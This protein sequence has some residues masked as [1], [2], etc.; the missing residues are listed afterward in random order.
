[1]NNSKRKNNLKY[2]VYNKKSK[3]YNSSLNINE[4]ENSNL[5]ENKYNNYNDNITSN[6]SHYNYTSNSSTKRW[7][8]IKQNALSYSSERKKR[9]IGK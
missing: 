2:N 6:C 4:I 3:R 9:I 7:R 8:R 5:G 1:M